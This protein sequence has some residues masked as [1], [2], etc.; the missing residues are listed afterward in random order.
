[1]SLIIT[2]PTP[3]DEE[4]LADLPYDPSVLLFD[5]ILSIDPAE[6]RVRCR[7]PTD[8][9]IPFTDQQRAHELRHP[10]HVAGAAM[11]HATGMLGFVHAYYVLGLRH[12]EGWIGYG[13]HIHKGSFR[14]LVPPGTP[15]ECELTAPKLRL[16]KERHFVRYAF[17]FTHEGE[18]AY[19]GEQTAVWMKVSE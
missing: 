19:E 1:M 13:T 3:F 8:R 10:R 16:G 5:Q 11:I 15:M 14:K 7:M 2:E 6:H 4:F 9:P 18:R 17:A 12:R